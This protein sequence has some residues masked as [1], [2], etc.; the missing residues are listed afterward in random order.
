MTVTRRERIFELWREIAE[1]EAEEDRVGPAGDDGAA[2]MRR[3][4]AR[5]ENQEI[6][7]RARSLLNEGGAL[8]QRD[9]VEGA[10]AK[11]EECRAHVHTIRDTGLA[12]KVEGAVAGN[13]GHA[14][15]SLGEHAKA[16]H[17]YEPALAIAR[18][19]GDRRG[20]ANHLGN[21][22]R[23]CRSLGRFTKAIEHHERSLAISRD[24]GDRSGERIALISLGVAHASL[25]TACDKLGQCA[26]AIEHYKQAEIALS[27]RNR[28]DKG[29]LNDRMLWDVR[30]SL[31]RHT[32]T[33]VHPESPHVNGKRDDIGEFQGWLFSNPFTCGGAMECGSA[34]V[35]ECDVGA[36]AV[37]EEYEG[38]GSLTSPR[39]FTA[40]AVL[41]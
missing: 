9:D 41:V 40:V 36:S 26:E 5:M 7:S 2:A 19:T 1:L 17:Y 10:L 35:F 18:E 38:D 14:Y 20:E 33:I 32:E 16:I 30:S 22:G 15:N 27:H 21:L 25:G 29:G 37:P 4:V 12:R 24:L 31:W 34:D 28:G 13:L 6:L 39:P 3:T 8:F 11:W 23:A